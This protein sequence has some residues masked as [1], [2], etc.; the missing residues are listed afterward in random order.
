MSNSDGQGRN[1]APQSGRTP[2]TI[3]LGALPTINLDF[4][5]EAERNALMSGYAKGVIDVAKKAHELHV[6]VDVLRAT[7][8]QLAHTTREVSESGNAVTVTHTQTTK[9]GRTEI[10]MGNTEEAKSGRLTSSQTGDRNWTPY[11]IFAGIVAVVLIAFL[12]AGHH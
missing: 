8:D 9:I 12:F 4:L 11:Y 6:D 3:T 7:L 1:I 5:P 2:S 10:K